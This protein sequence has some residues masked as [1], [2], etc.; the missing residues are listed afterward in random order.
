MA[1]KVDSDDMELARIV[2]NCVTNFAN[3]GYLSE[4]NGEDLSRVR[5][6]AR[7]TLPT[8]KGI[9]MEIYASI[10]KD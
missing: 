6:G 1:L 10:D 7:P 8:T 9:P 3:T 2:K 4:F 5:F